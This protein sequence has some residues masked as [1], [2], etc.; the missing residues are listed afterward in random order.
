MSD[1]KTIPDIRKKLTLKEKALINKSIDFFVNGPKEEY[2][3]R[4]CAIQSKLAELADKMDCPNSVYLENFVLMGIRKR[5]AN[6]WK[7][8]LKKK[9]RYNLETFGHSF[10]PN[11]D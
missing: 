11:E 3:I 1:F 9:Y 5:N 7:L 8:A 4:L 10:D 2:F 6:Q